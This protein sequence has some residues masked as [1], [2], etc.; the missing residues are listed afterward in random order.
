MR[1]CECVCV[2]IDD[3]GWSIHGKQKAHVSRENTLAHIH[4]QQSIQWLSVMWWFYAFVRNVFV[5]RPPYKY[6]CAAIQC[7]VCVRCSYIPW[8]SVL[9]YS[10]KLLTSFRIHRWK[11]GAS[12]IAN[13]RRNIV[14]VLLAAY[15]Y[16]TKLNR[17]FWGKFKAFRRLW[18]FWLPLRQIL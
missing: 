16:S 14:C 2:R 3:C 13:K 5:Y 10:W 4:P 7:G 9:W 8:F 6:K 18:A 12:F 11:I 1:V 15:C 17:K